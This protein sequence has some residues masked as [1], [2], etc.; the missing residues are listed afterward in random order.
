[1]SQIRINKPLQEW[2]DPNMKTLTQKDINEFYINLMKVRLR[3]H[4]IKKILKLI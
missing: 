2:R 1:M 4:K 3:K